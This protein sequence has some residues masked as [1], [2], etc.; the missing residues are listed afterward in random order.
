MWPSYNKN[1]YDIKVTQR[2]LWTKSFKTICW[3]K[4]I[5]LQISF[6]NNTL[7]NTHT[8]A[9][10]CKTTHKHICIYTLKSHTHINILA[11]EKYN[12]TS[13]LFCWDNELTAATSANSGHCNSSP[14]ISAVFMLFC[15]YS[16]CNRKLVCL[17]QNACPTA[18]WFSCCI[19]TRLALTFIVN[20][21]LCKYNAVL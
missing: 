9:S 12:G 7:V 11:A 6:I 14:D 19:Q 18:F 16:V 2:N 1:F 3:T 13:Y 5:L 4:P 20:A 21:C 15:T 10:I 8:N 17:S